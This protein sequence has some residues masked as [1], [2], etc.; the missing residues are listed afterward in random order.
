M[1][2][3][4]PAGAHGLPA[5]ICRIEACL[6]HGVDYIDSY[7]PILSF[8]LR[9]EWTTNPPLGSDP[10]C[11]EG[12]QSGGVRNRSPGDRNQRR[13]RGARLRSGSDLYGSELKRSR[14]CLPLD[15]LQNL[16]HSP[17]ALCRAL[18][19]SDVQPKLLVLIL[20]LLTL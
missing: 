15:L 16:D 3:T 1:L 14:H 5:D 18:T 8:V 4:G 10:G 11:S 7:K 19:C 6:I 13:I 2:A 12:L 9:P 17:R 20:H